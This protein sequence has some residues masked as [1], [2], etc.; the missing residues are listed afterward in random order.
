M[1]SNKCHRYEGKIKS[2]VASFKNLLSVSSKSL[3]SLAIPS[4]SLPI[5]LFLPLPTPC[6]PTP[7]HANLLLVPFTKSGAYYDMPRVFYSHLSTR[8]NRLYGRGA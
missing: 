6:L 5:L 2:F 7:G 3:T 8:E 1:I 4:A